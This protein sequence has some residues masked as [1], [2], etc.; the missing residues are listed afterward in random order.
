MG[1]C[2]ENGAPS[3]WGVEEAPPEADPEQQHATA[4]H[5]SAPSGVPLYEEVPDSE[6]DPLH[7]VNV[8]LNFWGQFNGPGPLDTQGKADYRF[9]LPTESPRVA[10]ASATREHGHA[11]DYDTLLRLVETTLRPAEEASQELLP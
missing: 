6:A 2:T 3:W 4:S 5:R 1:W 11:R 8:R 7:V 9:W 10:P